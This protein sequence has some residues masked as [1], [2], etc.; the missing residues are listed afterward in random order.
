[1]F[2]GYLEKEAKE[3]EEKIN[4]LKLVA[5]KA[6]KELESSRKEVSWLKNA[7]FVNLTF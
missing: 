1:M 3:K 6:K 7:K 5:V 2:L 4:K